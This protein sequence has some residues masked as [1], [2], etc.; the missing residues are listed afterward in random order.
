MPRIETRLDVKGDEFRRNRDHMRELVADLERRLERVRAGG[1]ETQ[2]ERHRA[3]GKLLARERIE[4][5]IE[6]VHRV[7]ERRNRERVGRVEQVLVEGA[8]RTDQSL[9]RGRTR[10]NTTVNF[11]GSAEPGELVDVKIDAATSTTLRGTQVQ[12]LAA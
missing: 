12:A 3:R 11:A 2:V 4:R 9:L 6:V 5:L 8:S 10:R 1:G 7:A